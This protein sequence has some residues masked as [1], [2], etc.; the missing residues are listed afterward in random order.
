[1]SHT[2]CKLKIDKLITISEND[3][4]IRVIGLMTDWGKWGIFNHLL[5]DETIK[6]LQTPQIDTKL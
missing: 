2:K 6:R 5:V 1:M 3:V 4:N